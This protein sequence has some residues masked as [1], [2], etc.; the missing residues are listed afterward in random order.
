MEVQQNAEQMTLMN[1][2]FE[3]CGFEY[4]FLRD[5]EF[6]QQF[7]QPDAGQ[8]QDQPT[9]LDEKDLLIRL[10]DMQKRDLTRVP[11]TIYAFYDSCKKKLSK[12]SCLCSL[13]S[14]PILR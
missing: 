3:Q 7:N 4:Y 1:F 8:T 14:C 12:S 10:R 9:A 5:F 2:S 13:G 6:D 11:S